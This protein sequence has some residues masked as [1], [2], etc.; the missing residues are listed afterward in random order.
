MPYITTFCFKELTT[1]SIF[2]FRYSKKE[3]NK[4][5]EIR[6][7]NFFL[8]EVLIQIVKDIRSFKSFFRK[9]NKK[10]FQIFICSDKE[11]F[12]N[13][14]DNF[15]FFLKKISSSEITEIFPFNFSALTKKQTLFYFHDFF[16]LGFLLEEDDK[17]EISRGLTTEIKKLQ[18]EIIFLK[19]NLENK[20][21]LKKLSQEE[22]KV[23]SEK[24]D[25][26]EKEKNFFEKQV[27]DLLS[28]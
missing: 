23:F 21:I 16:K 28:D 10:Q 11:F 5:N 3:K 12:L 22:K 26:C 13:Q 20:F 17:K 14:K 18:K 25:F 15:N 19:K 8:G 9:Y 27:S 2:S 7:F 4:S 24:L 6:K 1:K